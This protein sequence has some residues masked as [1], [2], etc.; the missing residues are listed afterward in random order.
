MSLFGSLIP[1]VSIQSSPYMVLLM[2][3]VLG[4]STPL[5]GGRL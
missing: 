2:T 1:K 4:I 3:E 5:S